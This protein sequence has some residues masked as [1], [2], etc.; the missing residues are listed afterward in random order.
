MINYEKKIPLW[1]LIYGTI[2][3][4]ISFGFGI[5]FFLDSDLSEA[6]NPYWFLGARNMAIVSV[7][8]LGLILRH[9]ALIFAGYQLRFVMDLIDV[10]NNAIAGETVGETLV[11]VA[12]FTFLSLIPLAWGM[13]VLWKLMKQET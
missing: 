3:A 12:I 13:R 8:V 6:F 1:I 10:V 11:T 9:S 2:Q 4:L 5:R 7:L